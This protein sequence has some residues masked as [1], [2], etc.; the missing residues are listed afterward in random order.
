MEVLRQRP[1][2]HASPRFS[3]NRGES[4]SSLQGL[5]YFFC[6][7]PPLLPS[8]PSPPSPSLHPPHCRYHALLPFWTLEPLCQPMMWLVCTCLQAITCGHCRWRRYS[9]GCCA[10]QNGM[11]LV[12]GDSSQWLWLVMVVG[13]AIIRNGYGS[14]KRQVPNLGL[15][16]YIV[17]Y[18]APTARTIWWSG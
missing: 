12:G 5:T 1:P 15:S 10:C 3:C 2:G 8:P 9:N 11:G 6:L 14:W 16:T 7:F 13:W 4:S 17:T 18:V